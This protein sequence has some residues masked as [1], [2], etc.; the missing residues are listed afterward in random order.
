M[1]KMELGADGWLQGARRIATPHCDNRPDENDIALL[2][3]HGISLPS[4]VFG[5]DEIIKLFCGTLDCDSR[6]A[7]AALKNLRVSAHFLIRRNAELI[8]F[9]PCQ[10]RA[11]HAGESRWRGRARCNDFSLG[12]ELEGTDDAQYAE[13]QYAALARL[14]LALAKKYPPLAVAGHMHIAPGRKTDPGAAF[15]WE[16]LFNLAGKKFDGRAA[17]I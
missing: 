5:G 6:P 4:G 10:M 15:D 9:A 16:K 7:F 14:I 17:G 11:W 12:A 3:V 1:K 13:A 2:V 8:Q